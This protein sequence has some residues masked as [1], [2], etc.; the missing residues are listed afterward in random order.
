[1]PF[2][3]RTERNIN[4]NDQTNIIFKLPELDGIKE[5]QEYSNCDMPTMDAR[6]MISPKSIDAKQESKPGIK[7]KGLLGKSAATQAESPE[8]ELPQTKTKI[9]LK[10]NSQRPLS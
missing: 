1:M 9:T 3:Q 10:L 2:S 8:D 7:L 6:G 5:H 4:D